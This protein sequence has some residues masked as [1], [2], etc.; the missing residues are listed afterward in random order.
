MLR[1]QSEYQTLLQQGG[2]AANATAAENV[3]NS[4]IAFVGGTPKGEQLV[5]E[6]RASNEQFRAAELDDNNPQDKEMMCQYL[7]SY[8]VG[9]PHGAEVTVDRQLSCARMLLPALSL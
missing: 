1:A 9:M 2:G 4:V 3:F 7:N 5:Q 8:Y 6:L